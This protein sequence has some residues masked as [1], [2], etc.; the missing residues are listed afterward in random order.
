MSFGV[1]GDFIVKPLTGG[2]FRQRPAVAS[3]RSSLREPI[4]PK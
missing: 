1:G 3:R 4:Y 2:P